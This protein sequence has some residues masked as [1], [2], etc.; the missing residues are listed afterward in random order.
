VVSMPYIK[1]DDAFAIDSGS[2]HEKTAGE[3]NYSI[4]K[5]LIRYVKNHG[6]SYQ[7]INDIVGA[8][9]GAKAEFQ[10]RVVANYEDKKISEN[11]DVYS[12]KVDVVVVDTRT[13]RIW[14]DKGIKGGNNV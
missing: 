12:N 1:K 7:T 4:T 11:G 14:S 13:C 6:L 10:R 9:E 8:C 3:L 5:L 2:R